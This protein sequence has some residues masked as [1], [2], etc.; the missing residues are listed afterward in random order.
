LRHFDKH[1][2]DALKQYLRNYREIDNELRDLNK[3]VYEKRDARKEVEKHIT[4]ILERQE[5]VE[6]NK[7]KLEDD[8]SV[9]R[10]QRPNNWNKPW[11]LS[12][13]ELQK[14]LDEYFQSNS[15][16]NSEECFKFICERRKKDLVATEFNVTRVLPDE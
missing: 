5:F 3:T 6:Y 15:T 14:L 2:M 4:Q 1:T 8:G 13:K 7:L 16:K 11:A 12:Q 9:F 10:I